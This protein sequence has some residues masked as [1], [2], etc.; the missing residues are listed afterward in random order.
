MSSDYVRLSQTNKYLAK[1]GAPV[2]ILSSRSKDKISFKGIVNSYFNTMISSQEQEAIYA[3]L[4]NHEVALGDPC[5]IVVGTDTALSGQKLAIN[6]CAQYYDDRIEPF[7]FIKWLNLAFWDF[8]FL[9][10][11]I[12]T[13]GIVVIGAIDK[14]FDA[15]KLSLARDYINTVQ[16]ST[17]IV[18]IET[19]DILGYMSQCFNL[20]PDILFQLGRQTIQRG[21]KH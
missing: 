9:K 2:T 6:V 16:G 17:I 14:N 13:K 18:I 10:N 15:K 7:P 19:A 4:V 5:L 1:C 8:D 20:S 21:V 3:Q 11:H 12:T